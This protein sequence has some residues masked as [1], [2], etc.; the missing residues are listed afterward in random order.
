MHGVLSGKRAVAGRV[1][2]RRRHRFAP[3]MRERRI[4]V[5]DAQTEFSHLVNGR[6]K[7]GH[8]MRHYSRPQAGAH[9]VEMEMCWR[10]YMTETPPFS[11]DP[12]R[13]ATLQPLLRR[14]LQATLDWRPCAAAGCARIRP[15]LP[16]RTAERPLVQP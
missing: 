6:F 7:G 16:A 10:T 12:A 4:A 9:A 13:I 1:D 5:L 11:L 15:A 3:V 8:T 2:P 14:L